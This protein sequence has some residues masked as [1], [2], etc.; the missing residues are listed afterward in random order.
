M[1]AYRY[2]SHRDRQ[3][4]LPDQRYTEAG[5][6]HAVAENVYLWRRDNRPDAA[7]PLPLVPNPAFTRREIEEIQAAYFNQRKPYDGHRRNI[8]N[9]ARTHIGIGLA[10]SGEGTAGAIANAQE[11]VNRYIEVD[12]LP[13][14]SK[15]GDLVTVSGTL[16]RGTR[17]DSVEIAREDAMRPYAPAE[18]RANRTYSVPR[19]YQEIFAGG[20][21]IGNKVKVDS[22]GR[23]SVQVR[24]SDQ[25][26]PGTYYV[27]VNVITAEGDY[28]TASRRT[29]RVA[30]RQ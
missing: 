16:G 3:G 1:A 28:V 11:F 23:F 5:G 22:S 26:M 2:L 7:G 15:V 14:D 29:V 4:R 8:V 18:L 20:S 25:G 9:P 12:P 6:T 13:V 19:P 17:A 24:L 30:A 21:G 10:R 27:T